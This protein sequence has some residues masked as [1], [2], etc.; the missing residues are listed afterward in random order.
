[1]IETTAHI[2]KKANG[3]GGRQAC[4]VRINQIDF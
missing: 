4:V 1:M 3:T 2:R